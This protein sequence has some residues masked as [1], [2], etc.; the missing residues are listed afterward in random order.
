MYR[1]YY[2]G[3][4]SVEEAASPEEC[5]KFRGSL[6]KLDAS[7]GEILWQ[8]YMLPDNNGELDEYAGAAV[9]GKQPL[10]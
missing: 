6:A 1:R 8:T 4:S 9:W 2:V 5:C 3:V 7:S 10:H